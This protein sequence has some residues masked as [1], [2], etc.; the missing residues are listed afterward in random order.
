MNNSV[1]PKQLSSSYA[2]KTGS[3]LLN[4]INLFNSYYFNSVFSTNLLLTEVHSFLTLMKS[5]NKKQ[6]YSPQDKAESFGTN[7]S[8]E[9]VQNKAPNRPKSII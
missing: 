1:N 8:A 4:L 3:F 5:Y 9:E 2:Y 7:S 6:F